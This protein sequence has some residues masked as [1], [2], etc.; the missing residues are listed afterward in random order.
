MRRLLAFFCLSLIATTAAANPFGD[1]PADWSGTGVFRRGLDASPE[2]MRCRGQTVPRGDGFVLTGRCASAAKSAT[3]DL[4]ATLTGNNARLRLETSLLEQPLALSGISSR[5]GL[6]ADAQAPVVIGGTPT[7]FTL[8]I[9]YT[10]AS[11]FLLTEFVTPRAGGERKILMQ[12][13]FSR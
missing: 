7:D 5:D 1:G 6:S 11:Q 9:N 13:R 2:N 3:L 8:Q 12:I 10:G 4:D